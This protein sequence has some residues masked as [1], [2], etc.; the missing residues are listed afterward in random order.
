MVKHVYPFNDEFYGE[1][2]YRRAGWIG[3]DLDGT[4][5][6]SV[7]DKHDL[8]IGPAVPL[9]L[10]RV[11]HW[12]SSGRQVK[13]F[14]ARAADPRQKR[15]IHSWCEMH[16]L[17]ALEITDR[18]DY[19]M[20]ALWDDRAVGVLS[21]LGVPILAARLTRWQRM[22]RHLARIF[23]G[24]ALVKVNEEKLRGHG[25]AARDAA[26]TFWEH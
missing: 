26:R 4:L 8:V 2:R 23:G 17:P 5:A 1:P 20:I 16:G 10:R 25:E 12:I 3:V 14:T 9:M 7:R 11:R 13:I 18:K 22:R 21:N 15:V 19:G 6:E 24:R